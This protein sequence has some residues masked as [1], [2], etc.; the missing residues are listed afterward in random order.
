MYLIM[1]VCFQ[2]S[3]SKRCKYLLYD[4]LLQGRHSTQ[5]WHRYRCSAHIS[6]CVNSTLDLTWSQCLRTLQN[7]QVRDNCVW[8]PMLRRDRRRLMTRDQL[9][10]EDECLLSSFYKRP[11]STL[12]QS[13]THPPSLQTRKEFSSSVRMKAAMMSLLLLISLISTTVVAST[14]DEKDVLGCSADQL[15]SCIS[16]IESRFKSMSLILFFL[17]QHTFNNLSNL[18]DFISKLNQSYGYG[19]KSEFIKSLGFL[20]NTLKACLPS[21]SFSSF[22]SPTSAQ[23]KFFQ[24]ST[25]KRFIEISS[26]FMKFWPKIVWRCLA[27]IK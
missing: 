25:L 27:Q 7:S 13:Y 18:Q 14:E 17:W 1:K 19:Q 5:L 3:Q 20:K 9:P 21:L 12:L 8:L 10:G 16:E 4:I 6:S 24:F 2:K 11:S 26:A 15:L 23:I 22:L